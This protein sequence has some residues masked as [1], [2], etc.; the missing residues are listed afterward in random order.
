MMVVLA[1]DNDDAGKR[2][3]EHVGRVLTE[4]GLDVRVLEIPEG[5]SD[6][7]EWREQNPDDFNRTYA[8]AL[9]NAPPFTNTPVAPTPSLVPEERYLFTHEGLARRLLDHMDGTFAYFKEKGRMV[10]RGGCWVV[11]KLNIAVHALS[12]VISEMLEEGQRRIEEGESTGNNLLVESGERLYAHARGSQNI[13]NFQAALKFADQLASRDFKILDNHKNYLNFANGTV[14]LEEMTL[15]EHDPEDWLTHV[16]PFNY[17]PDATCETL[18]RSLEEIFFD[19]P[20]VPGYLNRFIG[21]CASGET[22]EQMMLIAIGKGANGKS[23]LWSTITYC[24]EPLVGILPMSAFERKPAGSSTADLAS[25]QGKRLCVVQEGESSTAMDEAGIKRVVD[26]GMMTARHL[27]QDQ[28]QF[29]ITFKIVMASNARPKIRGQDDGIW[30]RLKQVNHNRFFSEDERNPYL[31]YE[32]RDEAEG[33]LAWIVRG[34]KEWYDNGLQ[35]PETITRTSANYRATSD[36]LAGFI[37]DVITEDPDAQMDGKDLFD[38]YYLWTVEENVKS[39]QRTTLYNAVVERI[40]ACQK[41][42]S[43]RGIYFKGVR[44]VTDEDRVVMADPESGVTK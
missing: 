38:A 8:L 28:M 27:Y 13:N 1:A 34:A 21:Y 12:D 7:T 35:E 6:V 20:D 30:R 29:P 26:E 33:I 37:G 41:L 18:D 40:P 16:L 36:E 25:L 9:R 14:N 4:N 17:D 3:N 44:L 2:F 39:W 11:D 42:R 10:Y 15:K 23:L 5:I 22:R 19:Q 43:N 31:L 32:L 24:L